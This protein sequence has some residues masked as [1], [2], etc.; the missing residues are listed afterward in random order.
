MGHGHVYAHQGCAHKHACTPQ[1]TA[2]FMSYLQ[3]HDIAGMLMLCIL[4][5]ALSMAPEWLSRSA[6]RSEQAC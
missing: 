6:K 2:E 3:A 5:A 1:A 4:L